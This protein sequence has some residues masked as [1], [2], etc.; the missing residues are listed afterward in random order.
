MP[1]LL[2]WIYFACYL[3]NLAMHCHVLSLVV[4]HMC[5]QLQLCQLTCSLQVRT[6]MDSR[7]A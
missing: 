6:F 3:G 7:F 1:L 2:A 4:P 5:A